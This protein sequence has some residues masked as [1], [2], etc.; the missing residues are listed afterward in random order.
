MESTCALARCGAAT[1]PVIDAALRRRLRGHAAKR[2]RT[3][4]AYRFKILV[5]DKVKDTNRK[6]KQAGAI[7]PVCCLPL[8]GVA[9]FHPALFGALFSVQT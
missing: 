9:G 5:V 2:F 4:K 3:M 1:D 7:P 8:R 6:D